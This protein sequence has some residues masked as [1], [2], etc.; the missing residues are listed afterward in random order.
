MLHGPS[1]ETKTEATQSKA[2]SEP[3]LT[4]EQHPPLAGRANAQRP[5]GMSNQ[6]LL[7]SSATQRR[8]Q[9]TGAQQTYGNQRALRL[10]R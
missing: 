9:A 8:Q 6:M 1:S 2:A 10:L 7:R 5:G 4:R 3:L